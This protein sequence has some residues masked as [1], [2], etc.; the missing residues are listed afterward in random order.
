MLT[1]L[2]F[3]KKKKQ[4]TK[5]QSYSPFLCARIA[6]TQIHGKNTLFGAMLN[7]NI[8]E[9]VICSVSG[10]IAVSFTFID[11]L[12]CGNMKKKN[13]FILIENSYLHTKL[14]FICFCILL[15]YVNMRLSF[16]AIFI[17][18]QLMT[19]VNTDQFIIF[20]FLKFCFYKNAAKNIKIIITIF[21][22]IFIDWA[23]T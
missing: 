10:F 18:Q 21:Q 11:N 8:A 1:S 5:Q 16:S 17:I 2:H 23:L 6:K 22:N 20:S 14:L 15:F 4:P 7:A 13:L 19:F 12:T 9:E 3:I